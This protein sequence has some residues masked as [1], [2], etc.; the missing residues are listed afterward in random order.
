MRRR[1]MTFPSIFPPA[2]YSGSSAGADRARPRSR[3]YPG[4]LPNPARTHA[5]GRLRP[6]GDRPRTS[7]KSIGVVLQ[8]NFLFRGT[9][10]ENIAA[11]KP[12]ASIEDIATAARM[13]GAEEFIERLAPGIRDQAG[14]ERGQP[15]WRPEAAPRDSARSHNR[16][17]YPHFRR[18]DKC[19]G[20]G[21]RGNYPPEPAADR[22][23]TYGH[24]R[25][26]PSFNAR[27]C[28]RD[29]GHRAGQDRGY[30]PPRPT[31]LALHDLSA[32]WDQQTRQVA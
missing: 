14:R 9:V 2:R 16:S 17:A 10:R 6:S 22:R 15:F 13:A 26:A 11:A 4:S 32:F 25:I 5:D 3:A 8:D 27:G 29:S 28:R 24:H 21:Q 31:H 18:S 7:R 1:W 30:R 20:P 12:D 19:S 23:R